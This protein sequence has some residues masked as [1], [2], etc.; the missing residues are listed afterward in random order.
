[1]ALAEHVR[2]RPRQHDAKQVVVRTAPGGAD[3]HMHCATY[4]AHGCGETS[5][6]PDGHVHRVQ[7]G[8]VILMADHAHEFSAT[9]CELAHDDRLLH[10]HEGHG[11]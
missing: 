11:A 3:R 6:G 2:G 10:A 7:W 8:R 5:P 1:M 4:D 9:R